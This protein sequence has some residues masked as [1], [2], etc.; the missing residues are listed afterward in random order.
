MPNRIGFSAHLANYA[1]DGMPSAQHAAYYAARAAG[2]TGLI[3]TVDPHHGLAYEKLVH[4]Y[5]PE[6]VRGYRRI[7]DAVHAYDVPI[8][9][10][11]SYNGGQ[12]SSMYSR[13][14]V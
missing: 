11:I 7:T 12:P 5:N 8:L 2:G 4:G 10:Q 1:E 3:I 14:P 13:L 9:S 6:V